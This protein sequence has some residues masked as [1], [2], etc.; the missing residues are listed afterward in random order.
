MVSVC[1]YLLFVL[2]FIPGGGSLSHPTPQVFASSLISHNRT[3]KQA[4]FVAATHSC[5]IC[6]TRL[7]GSECVSLSPCHH[8]VCRKCLVEFWGRH[9]AEGS[10]SKVGCPY[11]KCVKEGRQA[12]ATDVQNVLA[13]NEVTRWRWLLQKQELERGKPNH[14]IERY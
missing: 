8:A 10:V 9:I 2:F 12:S 1:F 7:P 11:E 5:P 6:L 13:E 4:R 14:I 3:V